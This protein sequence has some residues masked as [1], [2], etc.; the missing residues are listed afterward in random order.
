M[1]RTRSFSWARSLRL[2][3]TCSRLRAFERT[4]LR[5]RSKTR[6]SLRRC[7]TTTSTRWPCQVVLNVFDESHDKAIPFGAIPA[8]IRV[9]PQQGAAEGPKVPDRC[10][11]AP[12]RNPRRPEVPHHGHVVGEGAPAS[13]DVTQG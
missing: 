9:G 8:D 12:R 3:V 1:T 11:A 13:A 4:S 7:F 6:A 2:R 5:S 10:G